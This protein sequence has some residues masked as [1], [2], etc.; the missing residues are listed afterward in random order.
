MIS[1]R[2]KYRRSHITRRIILQYFIAMAAFIAVLTAGVLICRRV[3]AS[4]IWY[5]HDIVYERL[6]FIE[7]N[8]ITIS[9]VIIIIGGTVITNIFIIRLLKY[10]DEI[11]A[12]AKRLTSP[13]EQEISLRS[14]LFEIEQELNLSREKALRNG[15][16]AKEAEK[17]KNDLIMYLAHDLKTP[18]TSVVGYLTLLRDEPKLSPKLKAKYTGIALDK[19]LRLEELINE[20]FEITRFNLTN[21][22]LELKRINLSRMLEQICDEFTPVLAQKGLVWKTEIPKDIW[23]LC[24]PDKL[25]RVFDNLIRNGIIYSCENT[26]IELKLQRNEGVIT[27]AVENRGTNIPREK[28]DRVFEQ[29]YRLDSSRNSETGGSGLGLAIAKEIVKL[30]KGEIFAE[31]EGE[32]IRFTVRLFDGRLG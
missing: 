12:A 28:L 3:C 18:L 32:R 31:S 11:V 17:R 4:R 26:P 2:I 9:C 19:A 6:K 21:I 5:E 13:D 23:L 25:E 16:L 30:H 10:I 8:I 1:E 7:D 27:I 15:E 22:T 20:F 24:D 29:F 14:T